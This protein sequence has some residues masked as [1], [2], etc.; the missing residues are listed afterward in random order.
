MKACGTQFCVD[1]G[2]HALSIRFQSKQEERIYH[3]SL[4]ERLGI[5]QK[6]GCEML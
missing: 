2:G 1:N 5:L 6:F 3:H 4:K